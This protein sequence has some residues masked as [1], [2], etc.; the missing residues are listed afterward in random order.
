[1]TKQ[2]RYAPDV[3]TPL[4][5]MSHYRVYVHNVGKDTSLDTD[6]CGVT[7]AVVEGLENHSH[8]LYMD[9]YYSSPCLF[10]DLKCLGLVVPSE[11]TVVVCQMR[12]RQ[13]CRRESFKD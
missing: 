2:L 9:N 13:S 1:M 5:I 4:K 3:R 6:D 7:H 12:S 8:H 11:P 10:Q